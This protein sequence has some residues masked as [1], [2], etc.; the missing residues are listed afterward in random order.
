M[1]KPNEKEIARR[2][3]IALY[4]A[5]DKDQFLSLEPILEGSGY[6]FEDFHNI[7]KTLNQQHGL[8]KEYGSSYTYELTPDG[9]GYIEENR[10]V[11]GEMTEKHQTARNH[12]LEYLCSL[13]EEKGRGADEQW[14]K[15]CEGVKIESHEMLKD[16]SFLS[17]IGYV[18]AMTSSF[19][20]TD[21]GYQYHRGTV[22]DELI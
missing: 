16:L 19:R 7:V 12:I 1:N 9:I 15:I 13:Y 11:A 22:P 5:W 4:E 20:I 18:E 6:E 2:I 21:K 17:D 8:I 14:S 3:L 10:L